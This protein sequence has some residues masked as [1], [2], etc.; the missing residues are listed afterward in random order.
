MNRLPQ[1]KPVLL[2]LSVLL[3]AACATTRAPVRLQGDSA[4]LGMQEQR[5]R[6]LADAD[7]WTLEGKLSVSDGKDNNSGTLTWR[8]DGDRYEFTVRGPI[9]GRTFRLTGGPEGAELEG[10]DGGPRRGADA[11]SLMASTVGWQIPLAE[12]KRWALGLRADTGPA[13]IAFGADRLPS[14]LVQDGWTV[15]YKQWDATRQPA[16]PTRV[17]AEKAPYKVRLSVE[18]W[19]FGQ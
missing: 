6:S 10:L 9:T 7:H 12:L 17:F 2:A 15:D 1:I 13:D 5:E 3:L 18:N 11:E 4:T 19:S 16:M 14:R 8:Q